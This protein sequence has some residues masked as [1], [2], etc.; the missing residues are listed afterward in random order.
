MKAFQ[1]VWDQ[2]DAVFQ[3]F[4]VEGAA[5]AANCMAQ[6]TD[7]QLWADSIIG[8]ASLKVQE[9]LVN[10]IQTQYA[11][12][13]QHEYSVQDLMAQEQDADTA[14]CGFAT[15]FMHIWAYIEP[16]WQSQ[17]WTDGTLRMLQA[18]LT[19]LLWVIDK[20][21]TQHALQS[22]GQQ[23]W[24]L[25]TM[26]T[27]FDT[28]ISEITLAADEALSGNKSQRLNPFK[29]LGRNEDC[30]CGSGKKYKYCCLISPI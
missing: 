22:A 10:R 25:E 5:C 11:L 4:F 14:L 15:G 19:S 7:P 23:D 13:M 1:R 3:R 30:H 12:L 17:N 9:D 21:Q 26:K 18:L 6:P 8:Y 28:M 2:Q 29:R 16:Q 24:D 27:H 20:E